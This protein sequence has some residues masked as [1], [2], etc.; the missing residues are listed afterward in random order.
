MSKETK[1]SEYNSNNAFIY[2]G[3]NGNVNNNNK[4]NSYSVRP[5]SDFQD[6]TPSFQNHVESMRVAYRNCLKNKSSTINAIHFRIDEEESLMKLCRATY[7]REYIPK[8]SISFVILWP[9]PREVIAADFSDR[10]IQHWI[11]MR[12]EP[13][14]EKY[15]VIPDQMYSC[16][17]GKGNLAALQKLRDRIFQVSEGYRKPCQV[18][19]FDLSSFFM[20][21]DKRKLY[22]E[23][24]ALIMDKYE[25]SDKDLLLYLVR[26]TTLM[27]PVERAV[28]RSPITEWGNIPRKKSQ[29]YLDWFLGLAIGNLESQSDANFYNAPAVRWLMSIRGLFV[30]NYVDDFALVARDHQTIRDTIFCAEQYFRDERGLTIHPTK[31][32]EQSFDKGIKFLGGVVKFDRLYVNN[33]TVG[34]LEKKI[35]YYNTVYAGSYR[36]KMKHLER[37]VAII[38]SYFGL[39]KHFATYNIRKREVAKILEYWKGYIYFSDDLTKAIVIKRYKRNERYLQR[40]K[41]Q[42]RRDMK[43]LKAFSNGNLFTNQKTGKGAE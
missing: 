39:M 4:F 37:F 17:V 25:E 5:V 35:W 3:W 12:L 32:Y 31:R 6:E 29:Y 20:S 11:V 15:S 24:I 14:F 2:N 41:A 19:K 7:N 42:R 27:T 21:I 33:R 28:R 16:R 13:L 34:K 38:N 18:A 30:V 22:E 40:V 8:P 10:I 23:L 26:I 36:L 9:C 1:S 43:S